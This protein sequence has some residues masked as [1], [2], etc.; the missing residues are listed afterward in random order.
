MGAICGYTGELRP[1]LV[2]GMLRLLEHRGPAD[3]GFWFGRGNVLGYNHESAAKM[4]VEDARVGVSAD[5][6]ITCVVDGMLFNQSEVQ[7]ELRSAGLELE[8]DEPAELIANWFMRFGEEGFAKLDGAFAAAIST[9]DALYILRDPLGEKPLYYTREFGEQL[10]FA[11]EAKAFLA[12]DE[13]RCEPNANA[14]IKLLTFSFVPGEET[15]FRGVSQLLPGHYLKVTADG[16]MQSVEYWNLKEDIGSEPEEYYIDKVRDLIY[17]GVE[18]RLDMPG[19]V[20][21]FLSGGL[22]SSAIVAVLAD[23]GVDV[24]T[25]SLGFGRG[26]HNELMYADMVAQHCKTRHHV[27]HVEPSMFIDLLPHIIWSLD[28]PLC[29]CI[30]VPN[31]LL[32]REAGRESRVLF[33]GE[34]GDPL[35]GG[36]KNKFL[37]LNEWYKHLGGAGTVSAYLS[38]Y[39]KWYDNLD[40]VCSRDFLL[41][42]GGKP[43]LQEFVR[44]YLEETPYDS[45]LNQLMYLNTRLKGGQN[46]LV[47][48]DKM[49]AGQGIPIMSPLFDRQLTEFSF[50]VPPRHK[51]RGDVEKYVFK[52]AV[53]DR[54]PHP[55]VYRKKE[56][57]G[58]PLNHWFQKTKLRDFA[59]DLLLSRKAVGR[60]YFSR[61][62][63]KNLLKGEMPRTA[64]GQDRSGELLWMLLAVELW[65]RVFVDEHGLNEATPKLETAAV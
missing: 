20:G 3:R 63:V 19:P 42:T 21:A 50:R 64:F 25:Y 18:K 14:L 39:H 45:F 1:G 22:D 8:T 56:G 57:M 13:F 33:N 40:D 30:T 16:R 43:A 48:V 49:V 17:A 55:V 6:R 12:H 26:M 35:F 61:K 2:E 9:S 29:D 62:C 5:G 59:H 53:E 10:L 38:S 7:R 15:M 32:A 46:I 51:R 65:H 34:G 44:P 52:K 60:G 36:P 28:D 37:I 23:L 54:L 24:T 41:E 4:P 31:Y 27:L 11:S 58:V 47:K